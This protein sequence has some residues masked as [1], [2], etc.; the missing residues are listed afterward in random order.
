MAVPKGNK[1][2]IIG[3]S[4]VRL[5]T[6]HWIYL[7]LNNKGVMSFRQVKPRPGCVVK[8]T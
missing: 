6:H 1:V 8:T 5:S 3:Q 2:T 7:S 4:A